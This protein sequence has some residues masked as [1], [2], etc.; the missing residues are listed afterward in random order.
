[1]TAPADNDEQGGEPTAGAGRMP[2]LHIVTDQVE[3]LVLLFRDAGF[4]LLTYQRDGGTLVRAE[5]Q[6]GGEHTFKVG[7]AVQHGFA[8]RIVVDATDLVVSAVRDKV[9]IGA[10]AVL[11]LADEREIAR[12]RHFSAAMDVARV[13]H[14]S[15][16]EFTLPPG[17]DLHEEVWPAALRGLLRDVLGAG[18]GETVHEAAERVVLERNVAREQVTRAGA[19]TLQP[20]P[21]FVAVNGTRCRVWQGQTARGVP[22]H[23][24][25]ALVSVD[26][27]ADAAELEAALREVATPRPEV[28]DLPSGLRVELPSDALAT[29]SSEL[30]LAAELAL[31]RPPPPARPAVRHPVT[32]PGSLSL[33]ELHQIIIGQLADQD[34]VEHLRDLEDQAATAR[35][36]LGRRAA[37]IADH[38]GGAEGEDAGGAGAST[39]G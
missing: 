24:Y 21:V 38:L 8:R 31:T 19:F 36:E 37:V 5:L 20:T 25:V 9:P 16:A 18:A 23:A 1:V 12:L 28:A 2:D 3:Q 26:R 34:L 13:I 35:A 27:D 32:V 7:L 15:A 30:A 14:E 39:E 11:H 17:V 4:E 6:A 33:G 10:L 22:V 29:M